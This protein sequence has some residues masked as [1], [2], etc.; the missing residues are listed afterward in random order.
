MACAATAGDAGMELQLDAAKSAARD[1]LLDWA[2][3]S[4]AVAIV[5]RCCCPPRL[6]VGVA[7]LLARYNS[8]T[9][10]VVGRTYRSMVFFSI[11]GTECPLCRDCTALIAAALLVEQ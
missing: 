4:V 2:A 1:V 3:L 11:G 6:T 7:L 9:A 10:L 8:R 5:Q